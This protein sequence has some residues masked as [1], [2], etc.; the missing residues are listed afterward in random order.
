MAKFKYNIAG[1]VLEVDQELTDEQLKQFERDIIQRQKDS[2]LVDPIDLEIQSEEQQEQQEQI[3]TS[4][5]EGDTKEYDEIFNEAGELYNVSPSL[6]KSIAK[7]ESNFQTDAVSDKGA[8]GLMQIM[9]DTA[10]ALE[11]KYN[12]KVDPY[13]PRSAILGAAALMNENLDRYND[14]LGKALEAYNGG[15]SL[16]GKSSQTADYRDKVLN[17]LTPQQ[18]TP[19]TPEYK[20]TD[21]EPIAEKKELVGKEISKKKELSEINY[22]DLYKDADYYNFIE[23]YMEVRFGEKG[24][25]QKEE[26]AKEYV[27]RFATHM[28]N[29][30]FNNYSLGKE[31][32]WTSQADREA[33]RK[34]GYAFEVW[35]AVPAFDDNKFK[36]AKDIGLSIVSDPTTYLGFGVGKVSLMIVG[37]NASRAAR[38]ALKQRARKPGAPAKS[39]TGEK[40][41]DKIESR[42]RLTGIS[43]GAAAEGTIG[44]SSATLD[45]KLAV[46]Q[47]RQTEINK[48][49][50]AINTGIATVFGGLSAYPAVNYRVAGAEDV[51]KGKLF[52]KVSALKTV[53][54]YNKMI[55]GKKVKLNKEEN[56]YIKALDTQVKEITNSLDVEKGN[57]LLKGLSTEI[58][59][60]E[61]NDLL[62]LKVR[63]DLIKKSFGIAGRIIQTDY[64]TY[65]PNAFLKK[66]EKD[67]IVGGKKYKKGEYIPHRDAITEA[68]TNVVRTLDEFDDATLD[69]AAKLSGTNA[70]EFNETIYKNIIP[71]LEKNN[72]GLNELGDLQKATLSEAGRTMAQASIVS[73]RLKKMMERMGQ[74][75]PDAKVLLDKVNRVEN[76]LNPLNFGWVK[77]LTKQER[78]TKVL[79]TSAL[80]TTVRNVIGTS[81][82]IGMNM[83]ADLMEA[84][85]YSLTKPLSYIT[86]GK[87]PPLGNQYSLT[88]SIKNNFELLT[89]MTR[90]GMT[91]EITDAILKDN[92]LLKNK[93]VGAL[94][95]T[96]TED[97]G[98]SLKFISGL[99]L[100]Q[101]AFF[102]KTLFVNS[103]KKRLQETGTN[104]NDFLS[105]DVPIP[106]SILQKA[107]DDAMTLTFTYQPKMRSV[108]ISKSGLEGTAE[109]IA[110]HSVKLLENL[111]GGSLAITFPRFMANALAFQYRYSP[112]GAT[113]GAIDMLGGVLKNDTALYR[114]GV[115]NLSKGT[116][117][118]MMLT[119][120]IAHRKEV[121][122]NPDTA[123]TPWYS[124][125]NEDGSTFDLR[126]IFPIAPYFAIADYLVKSDLVNRT[127]VYLGLINPNDPDQVNREL[128]R[129]GEGDYSW[130][131]SFEAIVGM[132]L[133]AGTQGYLVDKMLK[134]TED[135]RA[136]D[137]FSVAVAKTI[138]D[139][140]GRVI[141]PGKPLFDFLS[142][143]TEEG[144]VAR[145]PNYVNVLDDKE[146]RI[147]DTE[148]SKS[149]LSAFNRTINKLPFAKEILPE[150]VNYFRKPPP[151]RPD[152]FFNNFTGVNVSP[153][154]NRIENE[155]ARHEIKPWRMFPRSG[156][157]EFDH[158]V[159]K[160][161]YEIVAASLNAVIDSDLYKK[162]T[163]NQRQ[164]LLA[165][166]LKDAVNHAREL[167]MARA[168]FTK[169]REMIHRQT[170]LGLSR[171]EKREIREAYAQDNE[172]A[173]LEK[174]RDWSSIYQ[175]MDRLQAY[176][177]DIY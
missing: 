139:F 28:R 126:P 35:N 36:A 91:S 92:P 62:S 129:R 175:Y 70:K 71:I 11:E 26:T 9:P 137:D 12:I 89:S 33:K 17:L 124:M 167:T 118:M 51:K 3:P 94:Q 50:I 163:Y 55:G 23:D 30:N 5:F 114:Q 58:F 7:I 78:K 19:T 176:T 174:T 73:R 13:D 157:R 27:D 144:T 100:T 21:P 84:G 177:F 59:G 173:N 22:K 40:I 32:L 46:S 123:G 72:I 63:T 149:T 43:L 87:V 159:I 52:E 44:V 112:F 4:S 171:R 53:E 38:V 8:Q 101:D 14:D 104:L 148:V 41:L 45:E 127:G 151:D 170:Y 25:R 74:L 138:S 128:E 61:G 155:I 90:Y 49:N 60:V 102:R 98:K 113:S 130:K 15:P 95:E 152:A 153:K 121:L 67:R 115:Q 106:T 140:F 16:V 156:Q 47:E 76:N 56:N 119:S 172:G 31:A 80:S 96:G 142:Q 2:D 168:E 109:G 68:L 39:L 10:K 34:A 99:N 145:D 86:N 1:G 110:Y 122:D 161:S 160:N 120:A 150:S 108:D 111:P 66:A 24:K 107:A 146:N 81:G 135:S 82:A 75:D 29:V 165:T 117:G 133:P 154:L 134:A 48:T 85:I 69:K 64:K 116:V 136:A 20:L 57:K 158:A 166:G 141:Q 18:P 105:K 147:G 65:G 103:I 143:F 93:L 83:A 132:K 131:E 37:K 97:L 162:G 79:V 125:I 42:A 169:H 6:L 164:N 54:D 88:Q 77:W